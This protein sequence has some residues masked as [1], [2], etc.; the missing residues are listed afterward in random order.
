MKVQ[1][2]TQEWYKRK[3]KAEVL[4]NMFK[5]ENTMNSYENLKK[6]EL[7]KKNKKIKKY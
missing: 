2:K 7:E 3:F 5:Y 4:F 1:P 6:L